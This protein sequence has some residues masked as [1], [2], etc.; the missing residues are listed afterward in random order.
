[1]RVTGEPRGWGP[2][3]RTPHAVNT[4]GYT[5]AWAMQSYVTFRASKA[6]ARE[7][8]LYHASWIKNIGADV[9]PPRQGPGVL[10]AAPSLPPCLD[11]GLP[12]SQYFHNINRW[13]LGKRQQLTVFLKT[14]KRSPIPLASH[15]VL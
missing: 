11:E 8:A 6:S 2:S 3:P 1:M 5:P 10:A 14:V 4:R 9:L 15:V 12:A 7:R 13:H